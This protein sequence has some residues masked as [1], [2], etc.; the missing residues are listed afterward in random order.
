[1][2]HSS[3]FHHVCTFN[4][5]CMDIRRSTL[6]ELYW[7][8]H[9]DC[10]SPNWNY[11]ENGLK[12]FWIWLDELCPI[13]ADGVHFTKDHHYFAGG[14]ITDQWNL[15]FRFQEQDCEIRGN[16]STPAVQQIN[17]FRDCPHSNPSIGRRT[18]FFCDSSSQCI[19]PIEQRVSIQRRFHSLLCLPITIFVAGFQMGLHCGNPS[20]S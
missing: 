10:G 16:G 15:Q 13:A 14:I 9:S 7:S 3:W 2:T 11:R 12:L 6:M 4:W 17:G 1:M 18:D 8:R 19:G 20:I 5:F